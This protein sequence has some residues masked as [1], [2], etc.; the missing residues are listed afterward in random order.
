MIGIS[1]KFIPKDFYKSTNYG[2]EEVVDTFNYKAERPL[3]IGKNEEV[4]GMI[5]NNISV[6][7][8]KKTCSFRTKSV[9]LYKR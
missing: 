8:V 2:I 4:L 5:K 1:L 6:E 7:I 9:L 3:P